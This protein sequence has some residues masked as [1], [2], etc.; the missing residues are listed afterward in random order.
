MPCHTMPAHPPAGSGYQL[1]GSPHLPRPGLFTAHRCTTSVPSRPSCSRI[2]PLFASLQTAIATST[3]ASLP[4][5]PACHRR[6]RRAIENRGHGQTP[7]PPRPV[8]GHSSR[9]PPGLCACP[10]NA[11]PSV[12]YPVTLG[13]RQTSAATS[14]CYHA[15]RAVARVT[16][17][18]PLTPALPLGVTCD[19]KPSTQHRSCPAGHAR[20]HHLSPATRRADN[21]W[22]PCFEMRF[23]ARATS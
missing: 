8:V 7:P 17:R 6:M 22:S 19:D 21:R 1:V 14:W 15:L 20:C 11:L 9:V 18:T 4:N 12:V 16:V 2:S 13:T 5:C 3:D 23:R 10:S